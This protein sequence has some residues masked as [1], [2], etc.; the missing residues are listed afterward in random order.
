MD[1]IIGGGK[2]GLSA[3]ERTRKDKRSAI[4][5]DE[6]PDCTVRKKYEIPETDTEKPLEYTVFPETHVTE[7]I[8]IRGG[9]DAAAEIIFNAGRM[10]EMPFDRVFPTAPVH[11]PAGIISY[12]CGFEPY[13]EG[14]DRITGAIGEDIISGRNKADIYCTLNHEK[15]CSPVCPAPA[16]CPVTGKKRETPLWK[17]LQNL[18]LRCCPEPGFKAVI[19]QS[20]QL[21][22][23]LGYIKCPDLVN[24]ANL[25]RNEKNVI[26]GTACTCHGV[27]TVLKK[28][29]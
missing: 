17:T 9:T 18:L 23:G 25:V 10:D 28:K 20:R 14:A 5:I 16:I 4:I 11:V 12:I 6:D 13:P 1:I 7:Y 26:I 27:V 3:F 22:P 24:A 29:E 2:Y 15:P 19:I 21:G 8:F